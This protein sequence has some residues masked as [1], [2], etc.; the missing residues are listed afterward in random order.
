MTYKDSISL[1]KGFDFDSA[2]FFRINVKG[3]VREELTD[4]LGSMKIKDFR[5][6]KDV[7]I[8]RLEG[9]VLDQAALMGI[10]NTLYEMRYPI[11]NIELILPR[12]LEQTDN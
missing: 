3:I 12:E 10:L 7:A 5:N 6:D 2:A 9:E 1:I 11:I 8:T 4:I